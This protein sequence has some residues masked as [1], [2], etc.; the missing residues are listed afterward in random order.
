MTKWTFMPVPEDDRN[1][2]SDLIVRK[3]KAR[4]ERPWPSPEDISKENLLGNTAWQAALNEIEPWPERS[5]AQLAEG[6]SITTQRWTI[7]MDFCAKHPGQRFSTS[8][9]AENTDLTVN[10]WRD[11]CRKL[12]AHLRANYTGLPMWERGS[13]AGEAMWPLANA[14][15]RDLGAEPQVYWGIT[16]EQAR[17][18]R[19][20]RGEL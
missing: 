3:Q 14:S 9:I 20:I 5:L 17:R 18:W 8:E 6:A 4:G 13:Y 10:E 7:A 19:N 12:T 2:V 16:E 1:E 15:G 11:A